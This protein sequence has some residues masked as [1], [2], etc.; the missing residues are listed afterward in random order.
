[1]KHHKATTD[2]GNSSGE[3]DWP[4]FDPQLLARN[5]AARER[6][7]DV[8]LHPARCGPCE[9]CL[10]L[11]R[12]RG[13]DRTPSASAFAGYLRH[14]ERFG[15]ELVLGA[16]AGSLSADELARLE[17]ELVLLNARKNGKPTKSGRPARS[18]RRT[19]DELRG[20]VL[21]LRNRGL[22]P[23]AIADVLNISDRRV[24][25]ILA[26]ARR[27]ENGGSNRPIH[28]KKNAAKAVARPAT[29]PVAKQAFLVR[30][31]R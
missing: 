24:Q 10:E 27:S 3:L 29:H 4:E 13:R 2:C 7:S 19:T 6:E 1:V 28:A 22:V 17:A 14:A 18:Q 15:S 16:A 25:A 11:L 26:E 9:D 30:R 5:I 12:E 8:P 20:Q 23:T 21:V 31:R